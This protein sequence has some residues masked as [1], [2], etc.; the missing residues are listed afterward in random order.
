MSIT[1]TTQIVHL[2]TPT[3]F[4]IKL[5]TT[6][7]PIWR[8]QVESTLIDLDVIGYVDSS[9]SDNLQPVISSASS[10]VHAWSRLA[11]CCV[12]SSR[13]C[14]VS[15]KAK[16]A[17]TPRGNRSIDTY[18]R[19]IRVV[20]DD[21]AL[22]QNPISEEDLVVHIFIELGDEYNPIVAAVRVRTTPISFCE[23][24]YVLTDY[25]WLLKDNESSQPPV[26]NCYNK[27]HSMP[28]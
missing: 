17:K 7:F 9:V 21:L 10:V 24:S 12:A 15:L 28:I 4:P 8:N 27:C 16:L 6:N 25:E 5:T 26:P 1:Q 20:A 18:I 14:I 22:A 2:N 3:Y 19:D 11:T 23:L 13:S